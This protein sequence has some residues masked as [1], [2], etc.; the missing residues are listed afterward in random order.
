M[1]DRAAGTAG[2]SRTGDANAAGPPQRGAP[3][4]RPVGRMA[5]ATRIQETNSRC[6]PATYAA[7]LRKGTPAR[8]AASS[9]S[10]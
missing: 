2:N 9:L 10:E 7:M 5:V 4:I 8:L 3:L 1:E 6:I